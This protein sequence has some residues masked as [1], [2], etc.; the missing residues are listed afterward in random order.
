VNFPYQ[1]DAKLGRWMERHFA[2]YGLSTDSR[3]VR[4]LLDACGRSMYAL[5]G[6]IAK[7]GAYAASHGKTAV[8]PDDIE[9]CVVR[10]DSDDAF[11]LANCVMN[12]DTSEALSCLRVKM[13]RREDPI[14]VLSQITRTFTDLA[15]ARTFLDDGRD[16]LDYA[17]S[18]KMNEYRAGLYY[19]AAGGVSTDFL[20]RAME[21]CV[22]ADRGIKSGVA[23][24]QSIERLICRAAGRTK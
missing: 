23:G 16:K 11:A 17:K 5:S 4:L 1:T 21:L 12:G 10:T 6:E 20:A 22:E 14:L 24:Y 19:R 8:E 3:A 9:A 15:A 18:M 2:G 13:N 7:V